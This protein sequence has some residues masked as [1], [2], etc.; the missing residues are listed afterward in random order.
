M[1]K[2]PSIAL[3]AALLSGAVSAQA[4]YQAFMTVTGKTQGAVKGSGKSKSNKIPIVRFSMTAAPKKQDQKTVT[5]VVEDGEAAGLTKAAS[6]NEVLPTVMISVLKQLP[7][8]KVQVVERVELTNAAIKSIKNSFDDKSGV[9][10]T[11]VFAYEKLVDNP[12]NG[13]VTGKD[14]WTQ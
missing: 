8:G 10:D 11:I 3:M 2:F 4:A 6:N 12:T 1:L 7:T 14:D 5:V 13:P 9:I